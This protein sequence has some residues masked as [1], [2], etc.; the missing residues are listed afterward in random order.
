MARFFNPDAVGAD[1]RLHAPATERNRDAILSV[2]KAHLPSDGTLLEIASGTG[3]HAAYLAPRFP[4]LYWQPTDIDPAHL[5]SISAWRDEGAAPNLLPPRELDVLAPWPLHELPA[6]V[7]AVAAINLIHIAPWAVAEALIAG[8]GR[9]L[10]A[11]GIL[12]LYGPYRRGGK[13]TADS[14]A[15]FD[16]SL[17]RHSIDWGV[18]DME[19]VID[20]A[21]T[22]G[23]RS[24]AVLAMP[25]NNF[26]LVFRK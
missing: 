6:P 26:S 17:K 7:R 8:A 18:R 14:N 20:L 16:L 25:A 1:A 3:E 23:F 2:L 5:A 21:E 10:G 12:Y 4:T 22:A 15:A 13:H 11:G 24:P 9:L 19:E